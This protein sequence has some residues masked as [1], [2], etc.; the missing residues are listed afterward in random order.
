MILAVHIPD[1]FLSGG[2]AAVAWLAALAAI[3]IALKVADGELDEE[4][5]PL[6][7]VLAAFVFAAQMINFP[8][9]GGT[10]GH[11]L[12]AALAVVML[13]PWLACI[14]MAVVVGG[15]ALIF[16]DGGIAAMGANVLNVG[17][18][19]A[20]V[21]GGLLHA[22][23]GIRQASRAVYLGVVGAC[24]WLAVMVAAAATSLELAASGTVGLQT[25]LIAMLATHMAIG[26]GEAVITVA[27]VRLVLAARPDL[28]AYRPRDAVGAVPVGATGAMG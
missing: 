14:V 28:L 9:A 5:V 1:G 2:V 21:C 23:V 12:G 20:G 19:G 10:S 27:A 7:G 26:I 13:G 18:L 17:V 25:V 6:V 24:A 11:L 4:R 22:L 8:V 16:A 3:L 15:Q